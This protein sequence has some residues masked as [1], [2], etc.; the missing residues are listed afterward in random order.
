LDWND[1]RPLYTPA[2]GR[3]SPRFAT[4]I[5]YTILFALLFI[6]LMTTIEPIKG[7][8]VISSRKLAAKSR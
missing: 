8:I 4:W 7:I 1:P 5:G 3:F 2:A 6:A